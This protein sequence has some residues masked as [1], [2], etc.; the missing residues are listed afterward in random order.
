MLHLSNLNVKYIHY[1]WLLSLTSA[2][3]KSLPIIKD[4]EVV[5]KLLPFPLD[6]GI[7]KSDTDREVH[8]Q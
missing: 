6:A 7:D 8:R 1:P 4:E 2:S 3:D 5:I